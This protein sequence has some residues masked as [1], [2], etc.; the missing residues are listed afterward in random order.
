[1]HAIQLGLYEYLVDSL[2]S[3]IGESNLHKIDDMAKIVRVKCAHQ[4]D[5]SLPQT[6]FTHGITQITKKTAQG[7]TGIMF[8]LCIMFVSQAGYE[9]FHKALGLEVLV[10]YQK[11]VECLLCLEHFMMLD[12]FFRGN[13]EQNE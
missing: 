10:A 2:M 12:K 9:M 1:M 4:S 8:I 6:K 11:L 7:M 13:L 3:C 5:R